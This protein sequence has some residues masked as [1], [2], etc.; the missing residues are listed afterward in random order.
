MFERRD[1]GCD[2]AERREPVHPVARAGLLRGD[3]IVTID[4]FTP[5][6]IAQ[7][8]L[9]IV[10]TVGV[11]RHFVVRSVSG[12]LHQIDVA[13]EDF[14]LQ[15]VATTATFDATRNGAPVKV[16]YIDYTQFVNYSFADLSTAFARFNNAGIGELILDLRYNG[17]GSVATSRDLASM[18]G[19][20]QLAGQLFAYL[21]FNDKQSASTTQVRFNAADVPFA[22]PMPGGLQRLIVLTSGGTASASELLINGLKPFIDVVLIGD[23]TYGKPYGFVPRDD[24]G[25]TYDAVNFES[26]NSL[27]V[28]NFTSGFAPTCAVPDD[29]THQLGDAGEGRTHAALSYIATGQCP[30]AGTALGA[31]KVRVASPV[32]GE[33]VRP[34]MFP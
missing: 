21:R 8:A 12:Q 26:L 5:Q 10:D 23:T 4:G 3:M 19:G 11:L 18:I 29:F 15:P 6:Q 22:Q 32:F 9:A 7:G 28:G 2:D 13:S 31:P 24:C 16:G 14:P 20:T 27:G 34:Q 17:G 1:F 30:V 33:T 25:I